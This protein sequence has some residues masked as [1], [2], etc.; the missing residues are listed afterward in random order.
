[1][2]R[3]AMKCRSPSWGAWIE[4]VSATA[5]L[6]RGICRSPS[7]GAWIEI[8]K[9]NQRNK[10]DNVAPPR[11]ERGLKSEPELVIIRIKNVAPPRGERGLKCGGHWAYHQSARSRSPSWGAWI[12][13]RCFCYRHTIY[14]DVAPPRGEH[15]LK[16]RLMQ[17]MRLTMMSLPLVGSVD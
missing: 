15:G 1:M 10:R 12:E 4:I 6:W 11:G 2:S 3:P 14:I 13:I 7:W 5:G 9:A 16:F 8:P 17:K